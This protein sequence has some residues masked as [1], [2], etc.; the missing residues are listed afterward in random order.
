MIS[1]LDSIANSRRKNYMTHWAKNDS[2]SKVKEHDGVVGGQ[3][4]RES[5]E[6]IML[7]LLFLCGMF[8]I[9]YFIYY[10]KHEK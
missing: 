8:T 7:F 6:N 5:I 2:V 4:F 10:G 9:W 1:R 3:S